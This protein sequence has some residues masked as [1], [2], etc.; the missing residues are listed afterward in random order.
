[1]HAIVIPFRGPRTAKSRLATEITDT[2]RRQI[3]RAMFQHVLNVSIEVSGPRR[4]LVV[5]GSRTAA[6]IAKRCGASALWESTAGHNEAVAEAITHLRGRGATTAAIVAADLPLLKSANIA[7]L[8]RCAR[9][10]NVG[11]APDRTLI[12]TN[13]LSLPLSL[14]FTFHFGANSLAYHRLEGR[15]LG[16]NVS[17][18]RQ[19]GLAS[20]VD[21][22]HDLDLLADPAA[23]STLP[24]VGARA[25]RGLPMSGAR[26][27]AA[28][29]RFDGEAD[30]FAD[31]HQAQR[32]SAAHD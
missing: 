31:D 9:D 14:A 15:R 6:A 16:A 26:L 30:T 17:V 24:S 5:T 23:L 2:A 13:A 4:V 21:T 10:G 12:G 1:M 19:A 27:D 8:E 7:A 29:Y 20:D 18:I 28:L 32:R 11:I 25:Y 3:A 22:P